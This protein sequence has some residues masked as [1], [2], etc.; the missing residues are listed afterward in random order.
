ML[1]LLAA[2]A[3]LSD[4]TTVSV[5]GP[6]GRL[7]FLTPLTI[8]AG[9][10]LGAARLQVTTD[11]PATLEVRWDDETRAW[12]MAPTHDVSVVGL[13]V[14]R[15][16]DLTIELAT[17]DG[18]RTVTRWALDIDD[19][20][21]PMPD[22]DLLA[23]E[24]DRTEP[25]HLLVHARPPG[26]LG[27][28][29]LFDEQLEVTWAWA[30]DRDVRDLRPHEGALLL[31]SGGNLF[32][33]DWTG[34]VTAVLTR[35]GQAPGAQLPGDVRIHHEAYPLDDGSWLALDRHVQAVP[36]Y[37]DEPDGVPADV[38][39][40]RAVRLAPQGF[41]MREARFDALLDLGRAPPLALSVTPRGYDWVH[42][43]GIIP[44]PRDGGWI[45]SS[46]HQSALFK[47]DGTGALTWLLADP[48]GWDARFARWLLEPVGDLGWPDAQHAPELDDG[49]L[50]VFDNRTES[51]EPSRVVGYHIDEALG[52]VEEA[53]VLDETATGPE[54]SDAL[55]DADV[56]PLTGNV[57]AMYGYLD[58][59]GGETAAEM[60]IGELAIAVVEWARD[61][62]EVPVLDLRMSAPAG[63]GWKA[64]RVAKLLVPGR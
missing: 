27:V 25:G 2:C 15:R 30:P 43:N 61:T 42:T 56:Q 39:V 29:L 26:E 62:P 48:E 40:E 59:W 47:I 6:D 17:E 37:P 55:G 4:S 57:L 46:R 45:V 13:G 22:I 44:D 24:P 8:E 49:V 31:E 18:A 19:L 38:L 9:S 11:R 53:F 33:L 64:Y 50:V 1:L 12:P 7:A 23:W 36:R 10:A 60:G 32:A 58:G 41:V 35:R 21:G 5:P 20:D 63:G 14:D 52:T 3:S 51:A 34:D 28:M 16:V 54:H